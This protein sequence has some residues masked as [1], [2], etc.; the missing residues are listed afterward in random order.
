[1]TARI[2]F[3]QMRPYL[4]T[5]DIVLF[6]GAG[7][8]SFGIKMGTFSK[9]SHVGMV[10][11][12]EELDMVCLWESTTLSNLNDIETNR[13]NKGVQLVSLQDRIKTYEGDVAIRHLCD[14]EFGVAEKECLKECRQ[15][16][17]GLPYERN[18][19]ELLHAA[20]IFQNKEDLSSLF[21]SELV[22]ETYQRLGLLDEDKPSNEYIPADFAESRELKLCR[23][24]LSEEIE[25]FI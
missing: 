9:W 18:E 7:P 8:L 15:E 3:N 16:F 17:K 4:N 22:A 21:C 6:S 23:G 2:H 24:Y 1:M 20:F 10:V 13:P 5:G 25:I 14:F 19:L 11:R 12:I